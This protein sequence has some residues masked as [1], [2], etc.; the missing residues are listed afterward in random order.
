M[1]FECKKCNHTESDSSMIGLVLGQV[2]SAILKSKGIDV[3]NGLTAS[4][5]T[6]GF[7]NGLRIKCPNCR[8]T[9]WK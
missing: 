4:K 5:I 9:S 3:E 6:T 7:L 8:E 1:S 2:T